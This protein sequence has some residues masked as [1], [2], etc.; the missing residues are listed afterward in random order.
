MLNKVRYRALS[1]QNGQSIG[2]GGV[3][4]ASA[5]FPKFEGCAYGHERVVAHR[6]W[7]LPG[8]DE[9][10]VRCGTAR[11]SDKKR[12]CLFISGRCGMQKEREWIAQNKMEDGSAAPSGCKLRDEG[13]AFSSHWAFSSFL[14]G[15]RAGGGRCSQDELG[16][17]ASV[18]RWQETLG[19]GTGQ[20]LVGTLTGGC[21]G[22]VAELEVRQAKTWPG[23]ER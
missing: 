11:W 7:D 22:R 13:F 6:L 17:W 20:Q 15:R 3:G 9:A 4:V 1:S 12:R 18:D 23:R 2:Q 16:G 8:R 21:R 5:C 14:C 19:Q 10:G